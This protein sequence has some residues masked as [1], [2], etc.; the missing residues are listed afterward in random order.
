M[1]LRDQNVGIGNKLA[2]AGDDISIEVAITTGN[3]ALDVTVADYALFDT[4][5]NHAAGALTALV[6]KSLVSGIT[7]ADSEEAGTV[8]RPRCRRYLRAC[9]R[10]FPRD[11]AH[12]G[13]RCSPCIKGRDQAAEERVLG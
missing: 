8:D 9:G 12:H 3:D 10:L 13:G 11:P 4:D 5:P 2:Y 7:I 6:S 1:A